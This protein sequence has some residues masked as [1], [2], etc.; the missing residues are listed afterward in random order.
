MKL[1]LGCGVNCADGYE[2]VDI[3]RHNEKVKHVLDLNLLPLPFGDCTVEAVCALHILEHLSGPMAL[4]QEV[5]RLLVC[6]GQFVIVVP[7]FAHPAAFVPNHRNFWS[8]RCKPF[9]DGGYHEYVKWSRVLFT[10]RW[11]QAVVYRPVEWVFDL[12]IKTA[13]LTYEKRFARMFPFMELQ[14]EL[15]K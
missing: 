10:H 1:D 15:I 12:L 9:F 4:V 8:Y 2:G 7:Y 13:P 3:C 14:I 5:H 11:Q 6:G